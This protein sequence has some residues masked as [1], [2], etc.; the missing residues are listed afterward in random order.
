VTTGVPATPVHADDIAALNEVAAFLALDDVSAH[1]TQASQCRDVPG[2]G[3]S[4]WLLR[5]E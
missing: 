3:P 2:T 5:G 1:G 4:I